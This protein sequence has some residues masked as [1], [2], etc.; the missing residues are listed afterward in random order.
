MKRVTFGVLVS[1]VSLSLAGCKTTKV[2]PTESSVKGGTGGAPIVFNLTCQDPVSKVK[3]I[4]TRYKKGE[5]DDKVERLARGSK[6][7]MEMKVLGRRKFHQIYMDSD[8]D[9]WEIDFLYDDIP[10]RITTSIKSLD[11]GKWNWGASVF[12]YEEDPRA[13]FHYP[14]KTSATVEL[15]CEEAPNERWNPERPR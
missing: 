15:R 8:P 1:L 11:A 3:Y 6:K 9:R 5:T 4:L 14:R 12:T 13:N 7:P 10:H 2:S